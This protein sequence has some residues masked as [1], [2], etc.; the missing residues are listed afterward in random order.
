VSSPE[1]VEKSFISVNIV[2]SAIVHQVCETGPLNL[3]GGE[4]RH[5]AFRHVMLPGIQ[6][7]A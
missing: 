4:D 3:P 1:N 7:L 2:A 5:C 6:A